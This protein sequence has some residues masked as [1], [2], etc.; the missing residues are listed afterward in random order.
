[1]HTAAAT[2]AETRAVAPVALAL[3]GV[4]AFPPVQV[5]V[6]R[7]IIFHVETGPGKYV[8]APTGSSL[9]KDLI[10]ASHPTVPE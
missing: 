2:T 6:S 8:H 4:V 7:T 1:M 5:W 9:A 3:L 10:P